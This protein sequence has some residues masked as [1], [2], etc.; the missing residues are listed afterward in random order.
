M[1]FGTATVACCLP[2][3]TATGV[4]AATFSPAAGVEERILP[5]WVASEVFCSV[6]APRRSP[7]SVSSGPASA[8]VL[9]FSGGTAA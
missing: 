9:P 6:C 5:T 3:T 1:T 7:R 2:T 4:P 8:T